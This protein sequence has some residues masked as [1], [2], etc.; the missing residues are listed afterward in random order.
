MKN[1]KFLDRNNDL[2]ILILRL[3]IG[4]LMLLHGVFK[5]MNGIGP[6]EGQ[7]TGMGLPAF[8]AYGVYIGEVIAPALIILGL[9]TRAGAIVMIINCIVAILM[10][11]SAD[12]F[13][14]GAQGGW[15]IELLGLYM[16]GALALVFTGGGK[17]AVSTKYLWD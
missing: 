17:Y 13:T 16:F 1:Y 12:V 10:V 6:I 3:S 14:L 9:A 11:H 7:I 2:G 15:A 4:I 5:L 8:F